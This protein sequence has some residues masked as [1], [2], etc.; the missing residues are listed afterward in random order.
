MGLGNT[1]ELRR[2]LVREGSQHWTHGERW[3]LGLAQVSL[4][5]VARMHVPAAVCREASAVRPGG[6]KDQ[7]EAPASR[8][9]SGPDREPP[10]LRAPFAHSM[11]G[12]ALEEAGGYKVL[13]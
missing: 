9:V 12:S 4:R 6:G 11:G 2:H 1:L 8:K 13:F 5:V 3:A 10:G 7:D